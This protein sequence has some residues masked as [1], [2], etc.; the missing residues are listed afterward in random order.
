MGTADDVVRRYPWDHGW[1]IDSINNQLIHSIIYDQNLVINDGYLI[2]N[3]ELLGSLKNI[4]KSLLGNALLSGTA[5]LFCRSDPKNLAEGLLKSKEK[6][7]THANALSG[8]NET[9]FVNKMKIL[10]EQVNQNPIQWPADKNTGAIFSNFLDKLNYDNCLDLSLP[11]DKS[12]ED[13]NKIYQIFSDDMDENFNESRQHWERLCWREMGG[14][15]IDNYDPFDPVLRKD[16]SYERVKTMMQ[17]ANEAYHVA[18]TAAMS[19]SLRDEDVISRP[20]T[21][22]CPAYLDVFK[23]S[24]IKEKEEHLRYEGLG[25]VLISV[26][27][28]KFGKNSD[29]SW[30]RE[31]ILN[32]EVVEIREEYLR[33]LS[34]YMRWKGDL[35]EVQKHAKKYRKVLAKI[36]ADNVPTYCDIAEH[37][38]NN[39]GGFQIASALQS[40]DSLRS[41]VGISTPVNLDPV[42]SVK[43]IVETR[44]IEAML[45]RPGLKSTWYG[46]TKSLA[47]ELGLINAQL[48]NDK[49]K[50]ILTPIKPYNPNA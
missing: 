39:F 9:T 47:R 30:V 7:K 49:V 23:K 41:Q 50:E 10:Q 13:F 31:L 36:V 18:Y 24:I 14:I 12:K 28:L 20:L 22:F 43:E 19:W 38:F 3:P 11:C 32:H 48:D 42:K 17:V 44:E 34:D 46:T 21:A 16:P 1:S 4:N 40:I 15:N 33:L 37:L 45:E 25:S 27:L 26:D 2:T 6:L 35:E 5:V 29:F 8:E